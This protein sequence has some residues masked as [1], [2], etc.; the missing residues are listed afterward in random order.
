MDR[1][2]LVCRSG[3]MPWAGRETT[4]IRGRRRAWFF[5]DT[6]A[7]PPSRPARAKARRVQLL[8]LKFS[9]PDLLW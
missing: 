7:S 4:T 5:G 2:F 6:D 9:L 8:S 3:Q 1:A